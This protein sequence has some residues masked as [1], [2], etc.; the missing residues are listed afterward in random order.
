[1]SFKPALKKF[2]QENLAHDAQARELDD[3]E[4]LIERGLID[5]MGLMNLI[6][7]I[8]EQTGVRIPDE[9]VLP[10]NFQTVC[11][12]EQTVLRLRAKGMGS[13]GSTK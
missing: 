10:E 8:E 11:A 13:A 1:M 5:S 3:N 12:V 2:I 7:F 9:D 4:S 6:V